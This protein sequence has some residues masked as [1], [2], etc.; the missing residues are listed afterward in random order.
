ME[1]PEKTA[2]HQRQELAAARRQKMEMLR[3]QVAAPRIANKAAAHAVC[4]AEEVAAEEAHAT[5]RSLG[6][7]E[8]AAEEAR[9]TRGGEGA[10][11][12]RTEE[13]C[14]TAHGCSEQ[15]A[16]EVGMAQ[17]EEDELAALEEALAEEEELVALEAELGSS[18]HTPS[19][20]DEQ[21]A[22]DI[23]ITGTDAEQANSPAKCRRLF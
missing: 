7:E 15:G 9:A 13:P 12:I 8:V 1:T 14:S 21:L 20:Y 23:R 19:Q 3:E 4:H 6:A 18:D 2:H 10:R 16:E 5:R 11:G 17:A 22:T